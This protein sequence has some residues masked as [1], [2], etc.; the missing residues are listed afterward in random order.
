MTAAAPPQPPESPVQDAAPAPSVAQMLGAAGGCPAVE[1]NGR[2]WKIEHPVQRAKA[3]LEIYLA[4]EAVRRVEALQRVLSPA[5]FQQRMDDVLAMVAGGWYATW[6]KGWQRATE[7]PDG[8]LLFL[9]SLLRVHQ[10]DCTVA[11]ARGLLFG[12]TGETLAALEVVSPGF[13]AAVAEALP[14]PPDQKPAQAAAMAADFLARLRTL[15]GS[16]S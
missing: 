11:D 9:F 7:G 13:F 16:G 12:K 8:N 14:V 10:P 15:T 5:A 4:G 2:V 3:E 1:F 6:G